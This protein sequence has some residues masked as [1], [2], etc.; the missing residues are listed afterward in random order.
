MHSVLIDLEFRSLASLV[1]DTKKIG[2][3]NKYRKCEI[4]KA[5]LKKSVCVFRNA[6]DTENN[7]NVIGKWKSKIT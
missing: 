1:L 4:T 5:R 7:N 2:Y 3:R 6:I